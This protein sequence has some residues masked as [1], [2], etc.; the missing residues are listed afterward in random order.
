MKAVADGET[1]LASLRAFAAEPVPAPAPFPAKVAKPIRA[2][3]Y[4]DPNNSNIT[5]A[6]SPAYLNRT[7][8]AVSLRYRTS[9]KASAEFLFGTLLRD[10]RFH[11][12]PGK[13]GGE[14]P[15]LDAVVLTDKTDA[16]EAQGRR[17]AEVRGRCWVLWRRD[18]RAF[19]LGFTAK[20]RCNLH[21]R[22]V[23]WYNFPHM[24]EKARKDNA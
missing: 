1:A 5:I 12:W 23:F 4:Q 3:I 11:V 13:D 9:D 17:A 18:R 14:F 10:R 19:R 8:G 2:G 7:R 22:R 6:P 24:H 21:G 16:K 15:H 20:R